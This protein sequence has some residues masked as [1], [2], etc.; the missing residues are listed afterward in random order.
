MLRSPARV[1]GPYSTYS[2]SPRQCWWFAT[3]SF[4]GPC[5]YFQNGPQPPF[6]KYRE[7]LWGRSW[8]TQKAMWR[9]LDLP[10]CVSLTSGRFELSEW[11]PGYI[12]NNRRIPLST[13]KIRK[14]DWFSN[15]V[16]LLLLNFQPRILRFE[17]SPAVH[18]NW[19]RQILLKNFSGRL[20]SRDSGVSRVQWNLIKHST[21]ASLAIYHLS[22]Y[23]DCRMHATI[24][25]KSLWPPSEESPPPLPLF[26]CCYNDVDFYFDIFLNLRNNIGQGVWGKRKLLSNVIVRDCLKELCKICSVVLRHVNLDSLAESRQ[27][28][29]SS[30]LTLHHIK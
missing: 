5:G 10:L 9:R 14:S 16:Y 4:P 22:T 20:I 17:R 12:C 21:R 13:L 29:A 30:A 27:G 25:A 2:N 8:N 6:W 24:P 18:G 28:T 15:V 3:T 26:Q 19:L 7:G 23:N 11:I 1:Y